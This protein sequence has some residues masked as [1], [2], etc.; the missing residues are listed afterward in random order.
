MNCAR[1]TILEIPG[2]DRWNDPFVCVCVCVCV[3]FS[4]WDITPC[5]NYPSHAES[6]HSKH[7][8]YISTH[9]KWAFLQRAEWSTACGTLSLKRAPR[10]K[11]SRKSIY[12]DDSLEKTLMLGKIEGKR[13]K[14]QQ[15]MRWLD[16]TT[17]S[18][19]MNL[20]KLWEIL[21][22]RRTRHA[23]VHGVTTSQIRF[24]D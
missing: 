13:R 5:L 8:R 15:R 22:Y 19:D 2:T 4:I 17:H 12:T 16:S 14:G 9:V 6:S 3:Y 20:G 24:G 23:A 21:R 1:L 7:S 10:R 18:V 11:K